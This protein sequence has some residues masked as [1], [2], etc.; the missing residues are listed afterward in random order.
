VGL[1]KGGLRLVAAAS[2]GSRGFEFL[3]AGKLAGSTMVALT[4]VLHNEG[5]VR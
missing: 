1:R 2:T 3:E 4:G 5:V